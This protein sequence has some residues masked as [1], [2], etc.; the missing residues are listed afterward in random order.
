MG[1]G[2]SAVCLPFT[3]CPDGMGYVPVTVRTL[4]IRTFT[5]KLLNLGIPTAVIFTESPYNDLDQ[6]DF[7]DVC[8][9]MTCFT[10]D[11]IFRSGA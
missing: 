9:A 4:K 3:E 5:V 1:V 11:S 7:A 6:R 8:P 2:S 10:S